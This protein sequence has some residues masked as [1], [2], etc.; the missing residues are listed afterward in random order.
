MDTTKLETKVVGGIKGNFLIPSYQRGY[1]WGRNEVER[2]LTDI[3]ENGDKSYCLQP[4]VVR[5]QNNAYRVVDGQQRLTTI[6][7]I[8][9]YI[10]DVGGLLFDSPRFNISYETRP[11]SAEFLTS[12]YQQMAAKK[13]ENI[14][15][16]FMYNA[17]A[18]IDRW[19][20]DETR[21]F[22]SDL[23]GDISKRLNKLVN[24]IWYEI[25]GSEDEKGLFSRLNSGKIAL[26]SA[27]LIKAMFLSSANSHKLSES[28]GNDDVETTAKRQFEEKKKQEEIALQWDNIEKDLSYE[29]LWYFLTNGDTDSQTRIDLIL[30]LIAKRP[31]R[32]EPYYTFFYFDELKNKCSLEEIWDEIVLKANIVKDWFSNHKF[33]H[34]IGYLIASNEK[35]LAEIFAMADKQTKSAFLYSLDEAI[36]R[37]VNLEDR[38][39]DDLSYNS[40]KD[41]KLIHKILLLF[42]V[43]SVCQNSEETD[44]FPFDKF[45]KQAWTLEHIHAQHPVSMNREKLWRT[46]LELQLKAVKA[47][48]DPKNASDQAIIEKTQKL[49]EPGT[50]ITRNDFEDAQNGIINLLSPP[51]DKNDEYIHTIANLAL[52]NSEI[53]S[54]LSNSVFAVKRDVII[55][56]DKAGEFI[57]FCT[58]RVF[59]KYY[60]KS[61]DIQT[62]FWCEDDRRGYVETIKQKLGEYLTNKEYADHA[63]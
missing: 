47:V 27:E 61:D 2:L 37:S 45:K 14:D 58:K 17:Y 30:D 51:K 38:K 49:L 43:E 11:K 59:L 1:R 19:F 13:D 50:T 3:Y 28:T 48:A 23:V 12:N 32:S 21:G 20:S 54:A 41:R 63:E 33:Y 8:Y 35:T 4:I 60:A 42:N 36:G 34:K 6:Y 46:W 24:V 31:A 26:T 10:R 53:N 25:D 7:L 16:W 29:P 44:W 56:R 40:E 57:P 5:K 39:L 15:Y 62:Y 9:K 52:L 18:C 55:D 22:K